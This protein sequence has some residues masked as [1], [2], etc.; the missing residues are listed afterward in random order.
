MDIPRIVMN[1]PIIRVTYVWIE[2]I[3]T[4]MDGASEGNREN[5]RNDTLVM[6]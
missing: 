1:V 6:E 3:E 4:G 2:L 5:F